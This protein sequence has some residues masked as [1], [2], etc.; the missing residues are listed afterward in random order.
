MKEVSNK[1]IVNNTNDK[2]KMDFT[3]DVSRTLLRR[4]DTFEK[5]SNFISSSQFKLGLFYEFS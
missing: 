2:H 5:S 4:L 1:N 3:K